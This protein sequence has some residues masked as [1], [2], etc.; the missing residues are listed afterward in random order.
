MRDFIIT[1]LQSWDMPMGGNAKDMAFELSCNH[2]VLY[3]NSAN[4]SVKIRQIRC[5]KDNLWV[6]DVPCRLLPV[7]I[8]PDG[9]LFDAI[10]H[11]NNRRICKDIKHA[12][13]ELKFQHYYLF[14]DNDIYKSFYC[15]DLLKPVCS[16]YYRRDF[17]ASSYWKHHVPRLE[18]LLCRK[19]DFV[20]T[21]SEYL[22]RQVRAYNPRTY[23][24]GQGVQ[25]K[26][27]KATHKYCLPHELSDIPHPIIGYIGWITHRRLDAELLY[28][29]AIAK[30]HYSF[31]LIGK[32]DEYFQAHKLHTLQNV[33]FL[34]EKQQ[35]DTI[36]YLAFFDVCINPQLVNEVTE[37]NYP[38]KIDEYLAMGKPVVA[39]A[40]QAMKFFQE[41]TYNC[42][43]SEEYIRCLDRA[44][45]ED[46]TAK[47][48]ARIR[49]AH[50]HSWEECINKLY[51]IIFSSND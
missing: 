34:G 19:C 18:A 6:L 32:E 30:P 21:N 5:I 1:S 49:Y 44:I 42:I 35:L 4:P 43:G 3:V 36:D 10:N 50:T 46:C 47:R 27:Y 12:I 31:V 9:I 17:L 24:I 22:A 29:I 39:T 15:T 38:R 45:S 51:S 14:I 13:K 41:Y 48:E 11:I 2:R 40:T 33:H 26:A 28:D 25:L 16:I 20:L 23:N 37:G 7:N 8:W